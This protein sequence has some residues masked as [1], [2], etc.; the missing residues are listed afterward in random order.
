MP[1]NVWPLFPPFK[2]AT[3]ENLDSQG[4]WKKIREYDDANYIMTA[5]PSGNRARLG[6]VASHIYSVLRAVE[7]QDFQL[8]CCRNPWG[9]GE[10]NGPWG[11]NS[12]EWTTNP[13]VAKA[14][15]IAERQDGIFWMDWNDFHAHFY[16]IGRVSD[17]RFF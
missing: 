8:I 7:I 14:L 2:R 10:W 15:K 9:R 17:Q 1:D 5:A 3:D 6:L 13:E 11:D 12:E 4:M 16:R